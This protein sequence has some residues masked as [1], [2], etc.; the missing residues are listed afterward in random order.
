MVLVSTASYQGF[1]EQF[2]RELSRQESERERCRK[3]E[4]AASA[5]VARPV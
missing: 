2:P 3:T 1:D 5:G 4:G